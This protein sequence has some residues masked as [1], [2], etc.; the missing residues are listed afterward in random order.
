MNVTD[1]VNQSLSLLSDSVKAR[2][3][4]SPLDALTSELGLTVS[5]VNH[6]TDARSDGGTCD[7][8]SFLDD[9]VILYA[10]TRDSRRENFTLAH[11]LGHW[12]AEQ[13]EDV[14]D[15]IADQEEPG[16]LLETVCDRIA[17]E[18]LLPK[19][20]LKATIGKGFIRAQHVLELYERTQA[21]KP[22]CAIA[23]A[24]CLP[25]LGAVAIV[26]RHSRVVQFA[27]I[28]P[29]SLGV[30]PKV[31]PWSGQK[32]NDENPMLRLQAGE[33]T[34]CRLLWRMPWGTCASY[35]VNATADESR[36]Y[37]VFSDRD[38]WKVESFHGSS[39][40]ELD[41]RPLISGYCC[42]RNFKK[43]G[44]PCQDC[45]EPYCPKCSDCRC[46]RE[47]KQSVIC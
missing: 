20:S 35:Y 33:S 7:G 40:H 5:A 43:R 46:V 8:M 32:L 30:W 38:L 26:D 17:Q 42:G 36:L 13:A 19:Q 6:L 25:G 4:N 3:A 45:G 29:D 22:A 47:A 2:F 39:D 41:T 37:I 21:S 1:C 14:Y 24:T 15:W 34:S 18:L 28:R 44:Y 27:S 10:P 9:G 31:F 11:E 23:L 12:L 16:R